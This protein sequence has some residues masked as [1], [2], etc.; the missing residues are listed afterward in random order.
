MD[1]TGTRHDGGRA[2]APGPPPARTQARTRSGAAPD[3]ADAAPGAPA[4][5]G[6]PV[7]IRDVALASGVSKAAVSKALN[8]RPGVSD[9]TRTRI[10]ATA[11]RLG[12]RPNST[13]AALAH[14]RTRTV[15]MVL[16]R[17]P[18]LLSADPFFPELLSGVERVLAP[19]GY[20]LTL[21]I[22]TPDSE[23]AE[24]EMYRSLAVEHRVAGVIMA[25]PRCDDGRF[26]LVRR[27][28]LPAVLISRPWAGAD[29]PCVEERHP[30]SGIA[31]VVRHFAGLGHRRVGYVH[32]PHRLAHVSQRLSL[33][34]STA[35][36]AGLTVTA[37]RQADFTAPSGA[38]AT[39]DL[40]RQADRPTAVFYDSDIM[41]IAG[42][43]T[44]R[45]EGLS[46]PGDVSVA[47][48]DDLPVSR[49]ISP[50][51]TTVR[52]DVQGRGERAARRLLHELG[53]PL[54]PPDL[55]PDST[56][57]VRESTGTPPRA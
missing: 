26:A 52:Q 3:A 8:G 17:P 47:G 14:G 56:L 20:T 4:D 49:W 23:Q 45:A 22:S 38:A 42:I 31:D 28:G 50:A 21:R 53:E 48:H 12:W 9:T 51:L 18:D 19:L 41:A 24:D 33:F 11:T 40:L 10:L 37:L 35:R 39:A 46:V 2:E 5:G 57:V 13:A 6:P 1:T 27:L 34:H 25:D 15:G 54:T 36:E 29:L 44:L 7:T 32:G 30:D 43:Q 16:D 55:M